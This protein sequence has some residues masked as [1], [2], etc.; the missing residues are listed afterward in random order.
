MWGSTCSWLGIQ[1]A[2]RKFQ[3]RSQDPWTWVGTITN[4]EVDVYGL[5]SQ[6]RWDKTRQLIF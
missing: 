1:D 5:V 6:E 2:S 4:T 3:P